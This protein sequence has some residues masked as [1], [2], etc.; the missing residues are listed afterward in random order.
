M[1]PVPWWWIT[2]ED[3]ERRRLLARAEQGDRRALATLKREYRL[4][5]W[6]RDGKTILI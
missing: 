3:R 2:H 4:L 6:G 1:Y 5:Y